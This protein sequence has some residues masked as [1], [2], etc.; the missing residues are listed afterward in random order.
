MSR[1]RQ[2]IQS[3]HQA[4]VPLPDVT[5]LDPSLIVNKFEAL[6]RAMDARKQAH[7]KDI[8]FAFVTGV[9]SVCILGAAARFFTGRT[10]T[11]DD[12]L[13]GYESVNVHETI[14]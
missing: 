10:R 7:L 4:E 11:S 13:L 8:T 9:L 12:G 6:E 14:E 1:R 5:A 3:K 2:L